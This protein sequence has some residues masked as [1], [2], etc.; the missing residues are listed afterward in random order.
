MERLRAVRLWC[1]Q[2]AAGLLFL[3]SLALVGAITLRGIDLKMDRIVPYRAPHHMYPIAISMLYHHG[4]PYA[5]YGEI[6]DGMK[7]MKCYL[8][9]DEIFSPSIDD[10]TAFNNAL[11]ERMISTPIEKP[12]DTRLVAA[13]DKGLVDIMILAFLLFGANVQGLF[14]TTILLLLCTVAVF[15]LAF[16]HRAEMCLAP[17]F[18]LGAL[19]A[20]MPGLLLTH[21]MYSLTNPRLFGILGLLPAIHLILVFFDRHHFSWPR[22]GAAAFQV[23]VV[24]ECI[25]VR[26]STIWLGMAVALGFFMVLSVRFFRRQDS[27]VWLPP[28]VKESLRSAWVVVLLMCGVVGLRA[29]QECVY[30]VGFRTEKHRYCWHNIGIGMAL[31]P[32]FAEK[33]NL[34][35]NDNCVPVWVAAHLDKERSEFV[36][37]MPGEALERGAVSKNHQAYEEECRRVILD[38]MLKNPRWTVELFLLYKPRL[39]LRSLAW[40]AGLYAYDEQRLYLETQRVALPD[41]DTVAAQNLHIRLPELVMFSVGL[42]LVCACLRIRPRVLILGSLLSLGMLI[43][44]YIP[45]AVAYPVLHVIG[46]L[47]LCASICTLAGAV[48]ISYTL[49]ARLTLAEQQ[50]IPEA[51]DSSGRLAA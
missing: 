18:I 15:F 24:V 44:S 29:Y 2:H 47:L 27:S 10:S 9:Y 33:Y 12:G 51:S 11:L 3:V 7:P 39:T 20:T 14:Y 50:L 1:E 40:A 13:D 31:H 26:S 17:V 34:G 37:G 23:L 19:F 48:A 38:A 21:E 45:S 35:I 5:M 25:H 49:L 32:K 41:T 6:Q 42:L 46:D 36:F 22:F 28:E 16:R 4:S 8:P 30:D 43:G